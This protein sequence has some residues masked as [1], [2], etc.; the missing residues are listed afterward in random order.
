M[1][2]RSDVPSRIVLSRTDAIGDAVVTLTTAGWIKHHAPET[3]VT[4][5]ARRYAMPVWRHCAHADRLVALE[6]L[7]DAGEEGA[8][9]ALRSLGAGAIV[10]VFPQR[11]VARWAQKAGIPRRVGTGRRWW[12]WLTCNERVHY[13]RRQSSLHEAQLNIGLLKP[14]G[15]P[16][17]ASPRDL[18]PHL[19]FRVPPPS[20]TVRALLGPGKRHLVVH[21]LLGSGVGWGL[22][23][24][25][26]LLRAVDRE[27]W[28]VLVTGTA[29]EAERYRGALPLDLP[30]VTDTGGHLDLDGV[31]QLI[32][33][34]DA[35]VSA[36]TGPLHLAAAA[37]I[38][39]VGLFSMR[40]PIFPTRWA[41]IG[42]DAHALVHDP[43]CAACA[44]G[45]ACDCI[46]RISPE[47]VLALLE[48]PG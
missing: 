31:I 21:P 2:E 44:A 23:N 5:V 40:R 9:E 8:V 19:G 28:R 11:D 14:F 22:P 20:E 46:T 43:A 7:R 37:G 15:L 42:A 10:H 45:R 48:T 3:H 16:V 27:R 29:A 35:F 34:S 30:H 47:R 32:G 41:P 38:R 24:F 4:V 33:A 17:P 1:P 6:E 13:S 12:N 36:S 25:A 39:A 26:A 18:V